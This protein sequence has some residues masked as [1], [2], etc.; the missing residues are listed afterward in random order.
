MQY[1]TT[2]INIHKWFSHIF[3]TFGWVVLANAEGDSDKVAAYTKNITKLKSALQH[4]WRTS[5][6]EDRLADIVI[7]LRKVDIL[8]KQVLQMFW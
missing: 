2:Y 3:E 5:K 4:K 6:D 1:E 8:E 7:M